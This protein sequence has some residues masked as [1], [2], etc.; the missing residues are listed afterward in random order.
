MS[1]QK[2]EFVQR[3]RTLPKSHQIVFAAGCAERL[4]PIY[5]SFE[6]LE[7]WG[8]CAKLRRGLDFVWESVD[9]AVLDTPLI[10]TFSRDIEELIPDADDF[11]DIYVFGAQYAAI[12]IIY[13]LSLLRAANPETVYQVSKACTE[14]TH[15]FASEVNDP[16]VDLHAV[17]P[18]FENWIDSSPLYRAEVQKQLNDLEL[19]EGTP[20]LNNS[21]LKEYR[22]DSTSFGISPLARGL[23]NDSGTIE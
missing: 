22:R 7:G 6:I 23:L 17:H 8:D 16:R 14:T 12:S 18:G 2:D 15:A 19:L 11:Q 20:I 13:S 5:Q 10:E 4:I 9:A 3:I 21:F 1:F